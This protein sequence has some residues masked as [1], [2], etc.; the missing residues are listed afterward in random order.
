MSG[1]LIEGTKDS[2]LMRMTS[3]SKL[4]TIEGRSFPEDS[5]AFYDKLLD[6][7]NDHPTEWSEGGKVK[8]FLT[9]VN[10]TSAIM[11]SRILMRIKELAGSAEVRV[12][13]K[14]YEDDES[15]EELGVKLR[16]TS[17]LGFDFDPVSED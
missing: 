8:F 9:Y 12:E 17:Q 11:L 1:L 14:Y 13:W 3:G 5:F 7:V 4:L 10:S 16:E 6:W 2:P 15:M